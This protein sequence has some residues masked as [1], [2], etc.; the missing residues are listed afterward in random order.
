MKVFEVGGQEVVTN[1]L[2]QHFVKR[3]H[4]VV[5][6]SFKEPSKEMARRVDNRIPIYTIGDFKI[7]NTN[8][9][10]LA[11]IIRKHHINIVINQ[12]GLPY[13]PIRTLSNIKKDYR[14]LVFKI[15]SIYH[16]SPD[17]NARIKDVEISL[18]NTT[19][20][21]KRGILLL[22][23]RIFK[24]ITATSMLHVYK[25]SD[26]FMVL[27]PN[28]INTFKDFCG[29]KKATKLIYQTNPATIDASS[30]KFDVNQK[31]KEILY[32]GRIDYNQKRVYRVIETWALLENEH[33]DWKLTIVGDGCERENIE[34][35][36]REL[37]LKRVS[38][39]GFKEP[40]EY[41]ERASLLL[42]TSEYEGFPLVLA[43][44]MSF[45][46]VP[47]VY[48][49]YKAVYDIIEDNKNGI[50]LPYSTK[51]YNTQDMANRLSTIM[52]NRIQ[53]EKMAVAAIDTSKHYAIENIYKSW[54]EL[55]E[56]LVSA[57]QN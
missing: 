50:I 30:F 7:S 35:Q 24:F 42:L 41:Y 16:N 17:T 43:E 34:K 22:K 18:E 56:K 53:Y 55:F 48:G 19:S 51:G 39:E 2:A 12:W 32:V 33:P 13:I 1:V 54:N 36:V 44:C 37:K 38:F 3:G 31:Q 10:K 27:S 47:A 46:V 20:K 6:A 40:K 52:D 15:I 49:S 4:Q 14:D 25:H 23:K 5:I 57:K 29:I 8:T 21:L 9:N 26:V 28:F 11:S 45:G